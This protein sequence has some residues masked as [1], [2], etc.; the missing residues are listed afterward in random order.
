MFGLNSIRGIGRKAWW[1]QFT[2]DIV[3][4]T[5]LRPSSTRPR[6]S[7]GQGPPMAGAQRTPPATSSPGGPLYAR[8]S[9][10]KIKGVKS[11]AEARRRP[12]C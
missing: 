9:P 7:R 5:A 6:R 3:T 1:W 11:Q 12:A 10:R 2:F 8:P 4:E